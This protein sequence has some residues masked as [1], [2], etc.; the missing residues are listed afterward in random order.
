MQEPEQAGGHASE[1]HGNQERGTNKEKIEVLVNE[2]SVLLEGADQ[3]GLSIKEAAIKQ[4]VP[5]QLDF[6]LSIELGGGKTELIGDD[7]T[8]KVHAHERFIAIANDDNS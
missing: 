7:Q 3:T 1:P 4:K 8:I 2:L 5:I 6:L